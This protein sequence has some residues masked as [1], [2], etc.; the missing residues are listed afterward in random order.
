MLVEKVSQGYVAVQYTQTF[1]K[2][3]FRQRKNE[4]CKARVIKTSLF[5]DKMVLLLLLKNVFTVRPFKM[6]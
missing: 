3:E 5:A 2:T 6:R 4:K 1:N